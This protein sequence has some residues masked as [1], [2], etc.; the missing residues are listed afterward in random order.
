MPELAQKKGCSVW[1]RAETWQHHF[2]LAQAGKELHPQA[3]QL[4]GKWNFRR[5]ETT[6]LKF[7]FTLNQKK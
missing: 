1:E 6:I 5:T 2:T 7:S 3:I 4:V